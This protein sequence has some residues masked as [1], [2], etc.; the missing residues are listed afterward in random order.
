MREILL[1]QALAVVSQAALWVIVGFLAWIALP[2]KATPDTEAPFL[3]EFASV[4]Y[5]ARDIATELAIAAGAMVFFALVNVGPVARRQQDDISR[6]MYGVAM[7]T[8]MFAVLLRAWGLPFKP[9]PWVWFVVV[10]YLAFG[11]GAAVGAEFLIRVWVRKP[12]PDDATSAVGP[13][14]GEAGGDPEEG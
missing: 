6:V 9:W 5:N 14:K 3:L 7:A 12:R 8:V 10:G 2:G 13:T 11:V 1:D 4:L